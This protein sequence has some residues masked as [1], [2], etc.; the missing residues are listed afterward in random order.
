MIII[1]KKNG[2]FRRLE[3]LLLGLSKGVNLRSILNLWITD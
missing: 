3:K 1:F 2:R